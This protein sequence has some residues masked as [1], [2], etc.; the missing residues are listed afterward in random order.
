MVKIIFVGKVRVGYTINM[1]SKHNSTSTKNHLLALT[2]PDQVRKSIASTKHP[3]VKE[4]LTQIFELSLDLV[5]EYEGQA[6][7]VYHSD[8]FAR[9][10]LPVL[11]AMC[12]QKTGKK[13]FIGIVSNALIGI[14]NT[15]SFY[16]WTPTRLMSRNDLQHMAQ[17]V[18]QL[19]NRLAKNHV[20]KLPVVMVDKAVNVVEDEDEDEETACI[21]VEPVDTMEANVTEGDGFS[22][23]DDENFLQLSKVK[24]D[25]EAADIVP[26]V[27]ADGN[28]N[29]IMPKPKA[30]TSTPKAAI[31]AKP[32]SQKAITRLHRLSMMESSR[33]DR[34]SS[35][36]E[37]KL[38]WKSM[39][40][41]DDEDDEIPA[42]T[43]TLR[44]TM[45]LSPNH[46]EENSGGINYNLL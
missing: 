8:E 32:P 43:N 33:E 27:E 35:L 28:G 30:T 1:C 5:E 12:N 44:L 26:A 11:E 38:S 31:V 24:T 23:S 41:S 4:K 45:R 19:K 36:N 17:H 3:W 14:T 9:K 37:S 25:F 2:N 46:P 13:L 29:D 40:Q 34:R 7:V 20:D 10:S 39:L 18:V 6:F 42:V 16:W 15:M 21:D 22:S